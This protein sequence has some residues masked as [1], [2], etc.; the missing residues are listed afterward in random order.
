M[1]LTHIPLRFN[2]YRKQKL[3]QP[4]QIKKARQD[5]MVVKRR[6]HDVQGWCEKKERIF[7]QCGR[8]SL[9]W[10]Y[11]YDWPCT[12]Y[13]LYEDTQTSLF[14]PMPQYWGDL[15]VTKKRKETTIL[16]WL[17]YS[18]ILLIYLFP[19]PLSHHN[20]PALEEGRM[21]FRV[22]IRRRQ[23]GHMIWG[24]QRQRLVPH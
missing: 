10:L 3:K 1:K 11:L 16:P 21:K 23:F 9:P 6:R 14:P 18:G 24:K 15:R 2:T 12:V 17:A 4:N 19:W 20:M 22:F 8:V 5:G 7:N 13:S